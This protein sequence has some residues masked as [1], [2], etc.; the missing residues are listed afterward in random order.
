MIVRK[1]SSDGI[2]W[3]TEEILYTRNDTGAE[4]LSPVVHYENGK[5][6]I[7]FSNFYQNKFEYFESITGMDWVKIRDIEFPIHP[8][9][10]KPW[11]MDIVKNG[12]LYELYYSAGLNDYCT[13]M[14]YATSTDTIHYTFVD[15]FMVN[16]PNNFDETRIYRPSIVDVEGD[17]YLY[18]GGS[19]SV[20]QWHIGL[21]LGTPNQP[22]SF[23]G[24]DFEKE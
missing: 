18:Y 23:T 9:E 14:S 8:D 19:D 4:L 20:G 1:C 16:L 7:W 12:D 2:N 6:Q 10:L 5:Y 17:R 15:D 22:T 13:R 3:S 24:V 11:Y 21:T